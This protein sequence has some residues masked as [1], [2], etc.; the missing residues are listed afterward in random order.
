MDLIES[1]FQKSG[2]TESDLIKTADEIMSLSQE[3]PTF[4]RG[5]RLMDMMNFLEQA[6][7]GPEHIND[8]NHSDAR[9]LIQDERKILSDQMM[10][11]TLSSNFTKEELVAWLKRYYAIDYYAR[12]FR[13]GDEFF[14]AITGQAKKRST[15]H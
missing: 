4:K 1:L 15:Q 2:K 13:L 6:V 8:E 12:H 14:A 11:W 3:N 5:K 10:H 7:I 9:Q